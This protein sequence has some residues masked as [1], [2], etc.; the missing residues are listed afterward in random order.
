M[1]TRDAGGCR[2]GLQTLG[3]STRAGNTN[4]G[5]VLT[6]RLSRAFKRQPNKVTQPSS[7]SVAGARGTRERRRR[8]GGGASLPSWFTKIRG[9]ARGQEFI[10]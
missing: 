6:Y 10:F 9:Q 7:V 8:G 3:R 5:G 2:K 4:A 1:A